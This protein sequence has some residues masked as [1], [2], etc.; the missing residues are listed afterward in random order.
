METLFEVKEKAFTEL[1]YL[2]FQQNVVSQTMQ[3]N[4]ITPI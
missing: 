2:K 4:M 3:L 1:K